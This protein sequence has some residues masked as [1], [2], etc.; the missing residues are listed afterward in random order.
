MRGKFLWVGE[1]KF[2][3]RGVT[4]GPFHPDPNGVSY[5]QPRVVEQDF[6]AIAANGLNTVR[7]Y[8]VPPRW[9]LDLAEERGLRVMVGLQVEQ[10]A[11]FL[12]DAKVARQIKELVRSKVRACAGHPAVL[13][14]VIA[15]EI[16]ASIVRWLGAR[17]VE[18]FLEELCRLGKAEDHDGLFCYANYPTSEY[19]DLPFLDLVCF[20]VFLE[21]QPKFE[22]YLARLQNLAGNRPL[23]MTEVGLDSRGRG[24]VTQAETLDWQIR[25]ASAAGCAGVFVF[26][27]TDDWFSRGQD[28][29]DWAFGL[30]D[31]AR[32]PKPALQ[33]VR[34][35]FE[36]FPFPPAG[37]WPRISVVVCSYNGSRTI[38]D[39]LEG[40][41][42]LRYPN[43]EVIVVNDGSTDETASLAQEFPFR[44]ISTE[45]RGLSAA[46]NTGYQEA[47]GEIVA[48]IDDDASP[49][50]DWLSYIAAAF[51]KEDFAGVGGPNI[52]FPSDG[53]IA[54]CVASSPGGPTHVLLSDTEAEHIPGCN[55][56]F[57]KSWLEAIGGFD[58][59]FRVAGDDVDLCWRLRQ[60]GGKLGFSPAAMV[61]HH[62]RGSVKA[63][64][65]QQKGYG[66]LRPCSKR[67]GR[68]NITRLAT[69]PGPGASTGMGC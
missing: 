59:Q 61:W 44:L 69:W 4:Y 64:W 17:Q 68:R 7:T 36:E 65:K 11:S 21:S 23:V 3:I 35:A 10:R 58:P 32:K 6:A 9:L 57:R 18:R 34:K 22:A 30:T 63:Y 38:R 25:T 16:P 20:N 46:R 14:Y 45:N 48:Y 29:E 24:E 67:N 19:L 53:P 62:Y 5:P 40:L 28:V 55:M 37:P 56:A 39:C 47:T 52:P 2:Y 54:S 8:D 27:W 51:Q 41:A 15:N 12:D 26:A 33:V 43:Y 50:P 1:E 60:G 13:C 49:D 66:R 42:K 31:R